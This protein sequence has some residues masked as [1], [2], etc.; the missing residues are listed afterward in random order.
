MSKEMTNEK[1][2]E[3]D[4]SG[5]RNAGMMIKDVEQKELY[6]L[7]GGV[8]AAAEGILLL[9]CVLPCLPLRL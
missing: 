7:S 9:V 6:P 1:I 8:M 2:P 4:L 3:T 5:Q